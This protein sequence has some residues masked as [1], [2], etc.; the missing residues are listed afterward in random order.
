MAVHCVAWARP[1]VSHPCGCQDRAGL[2]TQRI[3]TL[4]LFYRQLCSLGSHLVRPSA[5]LI[6]KRTR[7]RAAIASALVAFYLLWNVGRFRRAITSH[8]GPGYQQ[9]LSPVQLPC[10]GIPG[11]DEVLVVYRTGST[12]LDDRLAVHLST[13]IRCFPNHL[14]FS[15]YEEIYRGEHILDVL[16]D[17]DPA[18]LE[19]NS[20]FEL[21]RRLRRSG[22]SSLASSE[23]AGSPDKF[24]SMSGK[25]ENPGWKLDKWKFL[26]M[27]NRTLYERPDMKW[28]VFVEADSFLLWSTLQSYLATLDPAKPIYA[29]SQ[30]FIAGVLFAHGGSGFVVSQPALQQVVDYYAAHKTEIEKFTDGHWAG[31]CVLGKAFTDS[32]VPFTNAWPAFQGDYPGLVPYA[33]ADGRSVPD[34]S[35]REW[36]HATISYHHMSP[37]MIEEFWH[38]EQDWISRHNSVSS[39]VFTACAIHPLIKML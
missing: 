26:P 31:D 20:D 23:L 6:N 2:D 32:G 19:N 3:M 27:L 9:S 25:T 4:F 17:V 28:Y 10:Q 22:R 33:R 11:A 14:I 30:M 8:T 21:Y 36:C 12:E 5:M 24:A 7:T 29:G 35:L 1:L 13:S 37:A 18:I 38:F 15:D 34:E 39:G 16:A